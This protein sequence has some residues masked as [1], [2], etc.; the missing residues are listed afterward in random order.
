MS[1]EI[2]FYLCMHDM[3]EQGKVTNMSRCMPI[4]DVSKIQRGVRG[5]LKVM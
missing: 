4:N 5:V 3:N 1:L 2:E